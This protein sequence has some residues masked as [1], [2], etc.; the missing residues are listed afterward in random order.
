[1]DQVRI[2][3]A[4]APRRCAFCHDGVG[5]SL[6]ACSRCGAVHHA[7]CL[8]E[9]GSYCASCNWFEHVP[10]APAFTARPR[11][12]RRRPPASE[13]RFRNMGLG[14]LSVAIVSG[15]LG[16]IGALVGSEGL[17]VLGTVVGVLCGFGGFVCTAGWLMRRGTRRSLDRYAEWLS[18]Q[19]GGPPSG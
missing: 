6:H 11:A 8:R 12:D 13:L 9:N 5:E 4:Q 15:V 14:C 2:L 7:D 10:G 18:R 17:L 19:P 3:Q 1:M 16:A